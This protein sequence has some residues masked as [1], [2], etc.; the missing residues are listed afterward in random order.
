MLVKTSGDT[1]DAD[2]GQKWVLLRPKKYPDCWKFTSSFDD[3]KLQAA[4]IKALSMLQ[5]TFRQRIYK[6]WLYSTLKWLYNKCFESGNLSSVTAESFLS[7]LHDY[8]LDYFDRQRYQI[9]VIPEGIIPTPDNSYSLGTNTPHFLLNFIDYLYWCNPGKYKQFGLRDFTFKY[10]NSVEHHRAQNK[11][12]GCHCID[13]LGNLC[14]VSKSSNSRLSDRDVKE[15]VE[16]YGKGNLGPNRQIIYAETIESNWTWSDEQIRKHYNEIVTLLNKRHQILSSTCRNVENN[17]ET[18]KHRTDFSKNIAGLGEFIE[19][20]FFNDLTTHGYSVSVV[21]KDD[22][23]WTCH[24]EE[25]Y[26]G[27]QK[28]C[29]RYFKI[30]CSGSDVTAFV[31][32]FYGGGNGGTY[33]KRPRFVVQIDKNVM[34]DFLALN[35]SEWYEGEDGGMNKDLSGDLH[36]VES[37]AQEFKREIEALCTIK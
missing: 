16:V 11:S 20:H 2:D 21:R 26:G 37:V 29:G 18:E 8:M 32:W 19:Q 5:V 35:S 25:E 22:E 1:N 34:P 24:D 23:K 17:D 14:L 31:G 6:G 33:T 4:V 7:F 30:G 3:G 36:D 13:N 9:D 27:H 15:K 10:W 28:W 12:D